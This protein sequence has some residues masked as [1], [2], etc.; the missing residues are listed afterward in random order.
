[1]AMVTDNWCRA[2]GNSGGGPAGEDD[3]S[4]FCDSPVSQDQI[5]PVSYC[6][7]GAGYN[8]PG[9]YDSM[10]GGMRLTG[11][12]T[13]PSVRWR[14]PTNWDSKLAELHGIRYVI[15]NSGLDYW[16]STGYSFDRSLALYASG[17]VPGAAGGGFARDSTIDVSVRCV[18]R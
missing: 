8:T 10:K 5:T 9:A 16:T 12:A 17:T 13:S 1:M 15:P 3:P 2:A 4:D 14:L 18:G 7:E 6:T 11:S